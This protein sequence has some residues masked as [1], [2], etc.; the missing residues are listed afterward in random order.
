MDQK[1]VETAY[2]VS[3][4]LERLS[5]DSIWA[6]RASGLRGS[7]LKALEP[8]ESGHPSQVERITLE[9]LIQTGFDILEKAAGEIRGR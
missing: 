6:H 7:L 5:A 4:M 9:R 1:L 2:H 8:V 3:T